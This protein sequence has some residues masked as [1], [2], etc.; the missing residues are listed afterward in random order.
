MAG[1]RVG[2]LVVSLAFGGDWLVGGTVVGWLG[3]PLG[4]MVRCAGC[5]ALG[6]W[7]WV[8]SLL[9]GKPGIGSL[10]EGMGF[11]V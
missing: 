9:M 11:V 5:L 8:A 3:G 2:R 4:G 7:L 10:A 6:V 1:R